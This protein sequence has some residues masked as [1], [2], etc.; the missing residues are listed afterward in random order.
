MMRKHLAAAVASAPLLLAAGAHA[1]V[2][3]S[4]ATSTPIATATAN[5]GAPAD[6]TITSAGSIGITAPAVAVTINSNN[7]V[8]SAGQIGATDLNGTPGG[9]VPNVVGV[10]LQGGH[11]GALTNTGGITVTETYVATTDTNTGLLQGAFASGHNRIGVQVLGS[12]AF[13]GNITSTGSIAIKGDDSYGIDIEGPLQGSV[14]MQTVTPVPFT[15]TTPVSVRNGTI[16]M[17]GDGTTGLYVAPQGSVSG[18]LVLQ[19]INATGVA[20]AAG[21]QTNA[22]AI[23][24]GVGGTINVSGAIN[25]TGYRTTS[26]GTNPS[27]EAKYRADAL[28]QGGSAMVVGGSVDGG[29]IVSAKP[30]PLST[31]NPDTDANNVPDSQ[32]TNGQ[33]QTF[34]SA[35][36]LVLGQPASTG[37]TAAAVVGVVGAGH[38]VVGEGGAGAYGFVNQGNISGSGVFDPVTTPNIGSPVSGTAMQIGTGQSSSSFTI[39]GGIYNTGSITGL[40]YQGDATGIHFIAGGALGANG[41]AP[42]VLLNDGQIAATSVQVSSSLALTS[43]PGIRAVNVFALLIDQGASVPTLV[44]N[45]GIIA[46]ITG[47]GGYGATEVAAV[48]DHSGTLNSVVNTGYITATGNQTVESSN[49]PI[50]QRV[51][52][53]ISCQITAAGCTSSGAPQTITQQ[54]NPQLAALGATV[55]NQTSTYAAGNVVSFQGGVYRALTTLTAAEDPVNFPS[56]WRLV[57]ATVPQTNGSIYFANAGS[58]LNV[59]AGV[60][61]APVLEMGTGANQITIAGASGSGVNGAGVAARVEEGGLT[62]LGSSRL[63]I[64]VNNGT[65]SDINPNVLNINHVNVGAN[66]LL[67]VAADPAG[68]TNTRFIT[69]GTSVFAQGA[70]VGVT[71]LSIPKLPQETFTIVQAGP[72]GTLTAGTFGPAPIGNAPFLYTATAA[73][74]PAGE[75]SPAEIQLTVQQKTGAQLGFDR[76]ESQALGGVLAGASGSPVIQNALLTQTTQAGLKSVFDQLLP[77]QG[78]GLFDALDAAAE[79]VSS[80]TSTDPTNG[81][82]AGG[83][84][85]L[86]LQEVNEDVHRADRNS[87]ST[88]SKLVGFVGGYEH[89][90]S[91]G[92]AVGVTLSYM[93]GNETTK[94]SQL[95][96]GL[97]AQLVE[98]GVYYRRTMG[99]LSMGARL[100]AGFGFFG[101]ERTFLAP[102]SELEARASWDSLFYDAH[103]SMAYEQHLGRFY[104]RP[105]VSADYLGLRES[106]YSE[107]GGG[108]GFDLNVRSQTQSRLTA[109]ALLVVGREW[110]RDAWLRTEL[111][112]GYREVLAGDNSQLVSSYAGGDPFGING[113]EGGGWVT[114][115]FSLKAGSAS[116]YIALEGDV[117]YRSGEERYDLRIAG[118]SIF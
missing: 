102:G 25:S 1:Q 16:N 3:I 52:I 36:A 37:V 6:I 62:G 109:T 54:L 11:T 92:G 5:N 33:I 103:L 95:G 61:V 49:L 80:M 53:D 64:D 77:N 38:G 107:H 84:T 51:A 43:I 81:K 7:S 79:A 46:T 47:N 96:T 70:Q 12:T 45:A 89:L 97:T 111:R 78:Q 63:G 29:I 50:A 104:A 67:Q 106:G 113:D 71:L 24:G 100:G 28:Q 98:A 44:N 86:W 91:G 35:P 99:K 76:T 59:T 26:R 2:T 9:A 90:G 34:G 114:A 73:F 88:Y 58:T 74:V 93:N 17:V 65:L 115:G 40:A 31:T 48:V 10:Q 22:V 56:G 27:L 14:L 69:S 116:S 18:D 55:Y 13:V 68:G 4:T 75:S 105:T 66:G 85:S 42:G 72:T 94:A 32:Q 21:R 41:A 101:S 60:V 39:T 19:S 83:G 87:P 20:D 57:G 30:L 108:D 23:L 112:G 118:R 82:P 15:S 8:T 117:D 110:G